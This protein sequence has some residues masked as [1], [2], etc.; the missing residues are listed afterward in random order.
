MLLVIDQ[1]IK[2]VKLRFAIVCGLVKCF[3]KLINDVE[4]LFSRIVAL[5]CGFHCFLKLNSALV[6]VEKVGQVG[7]VGKVNIS[8]VVEW[9][10]EEPYAVGYPV[11]G[12]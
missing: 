6:S 1:K 7:K 8:K 12:N 4:I 10:M 2:N 5:F 11:S 3:T 9:F